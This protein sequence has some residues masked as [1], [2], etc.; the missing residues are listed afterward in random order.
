MTV[1]EDVILHA[2]GKPAN[3]RLT[4]EWSG[5]TAAD[6]STLS[7]GSITVKLSQ[8]RLKV[9]LTPNEGATPAG[10]S[11]R[12]T[13]QLDASN[14]Y[15]ETW[16]VP[17]AA[18]PLTVSAVR[19]PSAPVPPAAVSMS[20]VNGLPAALALK[21]G[22]GQTNIFT[23]PQYIR[24]PDP[25]SLNPLLAFEDTTSNFV[26]F[27]VP[28]LAASTVYTLPHNDGLAFQQLTTDGNG[29]MFWSGG[30][31]VAPG[32][33]YD[34]IQDSG[35]ALNQRTI[36]NFLNGL[37]ASD[38]P[39][40]QRTNVQPLFGTSAGT[41]A[42]GND[43][44]LSDARTPLA[45]AASHGSGGSDPVTPAS[46]GALKNTN[47][48]LTST[49]AGTAGLVVKGAASQS[50]AL[51]EWRD[52]ANN[53]LASVDAG[54]RMSS[55]EA[56]LSPKTGQT[57]TSLFFQTDNL[58]RFAATSFADTL[59]FDRYNDAGAFKD[60]P[61][62]IERNGKILAN[63][64]LTVSDQTTSGDT[65][66]VVK[67]GANQG[68]IRLQQWQAS[69]GGVLTSVD[70]AG[71]LEMNSHYVEFAQIPAPS[72]PSTGRGRVYL[73]SSTGQMSVRK[74]DGTV[75]SLEQGGGGGG[76]S[77]SVFQDSEAPLGTINGTN[78]TFTLQTAPNPP[79]SL[80]LTKN[81]VVQKPSVDFT[82]SGSTITFLTAAIPQTGDILL[83]WYRTN[84][85]TAGGDLTGT[86]PN[87]QV[88]AIRGRNVATTT[89]AN[90]HCLVW[91]SSA[92]QWQP[93]TCGRVTQALTWFIPGSPAAGSYPMT[94]TI[95]DGSAGATLTNSRFV[96]NTP[97]PTSVFNI[98]R[99]TSNCSG[100]SPTFT[101]IY[102]TNRVLSTNVRA[103]PG[104]TPTDTTANSGD[105]FR[106]KIVSLGAGVSDITVTLVYEYNVAH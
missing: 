96:V 26:G 3:G 46:I 76:G 8:G 93:K 29:N 33:A 91:N 25:A 39:S 19:V 52:S 90:D 40:Q 106:V 65:L 23:A 7:T 44:R 60:R 75:V 67:A 104:F 42:Q 47:D 21:A 58:T 54:G 22:I 94:L 10:T 11:Y 85:S 43:S 105:Q 88:A 37:Q 17:A 63:A 57:A 36:L 12:V 61:L 78:P 74:A 70:A 51:Q 86:Y 73:D 38:E 28:S 35:S 9:S 34:T 5:F 45:H 1:I 15:T 97:G 27:R 53:L 24:K 81:G 68:S 2:D 92:A 98:E 101:A 16:V 41:V 13:Y 100:T 31:E 48:I 71:N 99:C 49:A 55:R 95:P 18:G 69:N 6:G 102:S 50:A 14:R 30:S 32:A 77:F 64:D 20:Q 56:L 59:N 103:I 82:V 72:A 79:G 80:E 4:I 66:F 87:P 89:P 62:Q 83:A 84:S